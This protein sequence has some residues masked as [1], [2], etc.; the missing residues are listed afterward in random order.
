[1][2]KAKAKRFVSDGCAIR[3]VH[4]D[5]VAAAKKE[6]LGEPEL[7]RLAAIFKAL[8]DPTRLRIV[9]A[10]AGG[11]MCVCDLSAFLGLSESAVSHQLRRLKDLALVRHRRDGQVLYYSLD[12]DHVTALLKLGLEHIRE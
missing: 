7:D 5:R 2:G 1:M 9:T 4:L 8:G 12:D 3:V 6:A 11:E 10:L